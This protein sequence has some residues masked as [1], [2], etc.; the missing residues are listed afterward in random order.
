VEPDRRTDAEL[1]AVAGRDPEA[2]GAFY[3]RHEA[4][5]VGYL[6]RRAPAR[7]S[8]DLAAETFA[9]VVWQCRRGA[10]VEEPLG[11]LFA[12]ARSKL[13]DYHR[14]GHVADRARRRLGLERLAFDDEALARVEAL[15]ED[16][17][18]HPLLD[19]LP[20]DQREAVVAR[21]LD[22]RSYAEIAAAQGAPEATVRQRVSRGLAR[23]RRRLE[24]A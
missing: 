11:W 1:L 20:E 13:A 7:D 23:L 22:E 9:E 16:P 21:V 2:L 17:R 8:A 4:A 15:A 12:I 6:A 5:V 19:E 3:D 14:R 10:T 24:E 18:A